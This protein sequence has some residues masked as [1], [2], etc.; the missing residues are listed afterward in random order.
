MS[1]SFSR[2]ANRC[3]QVQKQLEEQRAKLTIALNVMNIKNSRDIANMPDK[4]GFYQVDIL[5]QNGLKTSENIQLPIHSQMSGTTEII[6]T[7][8]LLI[9][10]I[11][12]KGA[13][14]NLR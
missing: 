12:I 10:K 6:L 5:F 2:N 4:D 1:I 9:E 11:G 3:L 14:W 7:E 8:K 13:M